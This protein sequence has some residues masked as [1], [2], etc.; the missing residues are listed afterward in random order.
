MKS[1]KILLIGVLAVAAVAL[2]VFVRNKQ[3]VESPAQEGPFQV[4]FN[5]QGQLS[6]LSAEKTDTLAVIDIEVADNNQR[7]ARGLMYRESIPKNAGMLFIFEQE[8]MQSFWMKNTYI[9]LDMVFVNNNNQIVTIRHNTT[10]LQEWSYAS[11]KPA[12]Y[13]VEVNAGYCRQN[14]IE[15]GNTIEFSINK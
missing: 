12:R 5:K 15:E 2:G 8:D 14:N 4:A 1:K 7:R 3:G 6:F 11:T 9:P 13:V 10:P